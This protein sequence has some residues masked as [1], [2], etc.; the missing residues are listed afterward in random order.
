VRASGA[1]GI[2][3]EDS[4]FG[5][6]DRLRP[7][8]EAA[9][10]VAAARAAAERARVPLFVNARTDVHWLRLGDESTRLERTIERLAAYVDAGADG[11]FAPGVTGRT[12][13]ARLVEQ[14]GAPLNVLASPA[15]PPPAELAALGVARVSS[16][17]GPSRA[18]LGLAARL[19]DE[20][21]G[22][23]A[24]TAMSEGALPYDDAQSLFAR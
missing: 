6:V 14:V 24:L 7:I 9:A 11:V 8:A 16:G 13:I 18:L 17:S 23:G 15:L 12:E 22:T 1:V 19:A 5:A 20:F 21:T 3:I 2:N 10:R 4:A